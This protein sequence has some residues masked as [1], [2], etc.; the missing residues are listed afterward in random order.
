M[1]RRL[2]LKL[3]PWAFLLVLGAVVAAI[4]FSID[5]YRHRFVRS[6]ADLVRLLPRGESTIIFANFTV[7]RR[8]GMMHL[9]AGARPAEAPEYNQFVRQTRFDYT[10]DI[11][12]VAAAIDGGQN[13]FVAR[14][15]FDWD[16][17]RRYIAAQG[18]S[19]PEGN[20]CR[21]LTSQSG[22]WASL[23]L[24]QP[25]VIALSAGKEVSR[26]IF[27][28]QKRREKKPTPSEPVW[29][30]VSEKLLKNPVDL[31][32]PLR[33]F[34]ITL[35]SADSVLISLG[36]AGANADAAFEI[37]LDA[38]C[39]NSVTAGTIR[40]QL[41]LQTRLLKLELTREREQPNPADLTGLLT[42]GSFQVIDQ[43]VIGKWPV[44]KEL[45]KALQ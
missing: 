41:E 3:P 14:G 37:R 34:A 13:F 29:V 18:G 15:R 44:R 6:N 33:I 25:D 28:Y 27:D 31:P 22:R 1:T 4:L 35:Q 11:D 17:L 43:H 10:K 5:S 8:A 32:L 40:N 30:H 39:P 23:W 21:V 12:A 38:A 16:A 24:V 26:A 42:A 20:F 45:L 36:P 9:L 7:L 2:R 19:C